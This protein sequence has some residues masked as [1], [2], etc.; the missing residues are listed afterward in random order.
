MRKTAM[1]AALACS[2]LAAAGCKQETT[3]PAPE[4]TETMMVPVPGPTS[5]A[6]VGVP[7]PGPTS[8]EVVV[9]PGPTVTETVTPKAS[10]TPQ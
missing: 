4:A 6:V 1:I 10:P 7:V 8:T 9:V 2:L 3:Y 5:T